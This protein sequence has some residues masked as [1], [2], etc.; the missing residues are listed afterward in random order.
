MPQAIYLPTGPWSDCQAMTVQ[1][2]GR[3]PDGAALKQWRL[4]IGLSREALGAAAGGVSSATVRRI[5]HGEVRPHPSTVAALLGA[6]RARSGA[7][8]TSDDHEA[9][10]GGPVGKEGE[11]GARL[12]G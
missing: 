7:V 10:G 9:A 11:D 4:S 5:E 6:L 12:R 3:P 2:I 1:M 8:L